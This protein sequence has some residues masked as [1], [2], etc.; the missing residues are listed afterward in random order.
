MGP[1]PEKCADWL[2]GRRSAATCQRGSVAKEACI[3]VQCV[4][5]GRRDKQLCGPVAPCTERDVRDRRSAPSSDRLAEAPSASAA[6]RARMLMETALGRQTRPREPQPLHH[7]V[8]LQDRTPA[9][10]PA[11]ETVPA[12]RILVRQGIELQS[13]PGEGADALQ[14]SPFAREDDTGSVDVPYSGGA[15]V[16]QGRCACR[17]NGRCCCIADTPA[18]LVG[19]QEGLHRS[20]SA[21][22]RA[23]KEAS[24]PG[25]VMGDKA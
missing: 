21:S 4:D 22:M 3:P 14:V 9:L 20:A 24:R 15:A 8:A 18:V 7:A 16:G 19:A 11:T 25:R 12:P 1:L 2:A 17:G 10:V 13:L 6:E 23:R 5:I